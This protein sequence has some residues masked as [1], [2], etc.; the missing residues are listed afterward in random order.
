MTKRVAL[1]ALT[2]LAICLPATAVARDAAIMAKTA[3]HEARSDGDRGMLAVCLVIRNRGGKSGKV[4]DV[5]RKPSQFSVWSEGG[6]A[7][8]TVIPAKDPHYA[9]ALRVARRV[10][11][12]KVRDIT[13]GAT[14]YHEVS[15]RPA[16]AKRLTPTVRIGRHQFYRERD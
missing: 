10:L 13:R 5:V 15:I 16:W 14:H 7:R 11:A 9:K 8:K 4:R 12:G 2:L 1:A 6:A 3:Y